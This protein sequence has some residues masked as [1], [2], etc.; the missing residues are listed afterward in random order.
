LLDAQAVNTL[1]L[2]LEVWGSTL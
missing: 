1:A 2:E